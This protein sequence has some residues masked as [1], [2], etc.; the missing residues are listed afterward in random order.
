MLHGTSELNF[1]VLNPTSFAVKIFFVF[2]RTVE[3]AR[4]VHRQKGFT[5]SV[6]HHQKDG[7]IRRLLIAVTGLLTHRGTYVR[8]EDSESAATVLW[9]CKKIATQWD[10][11]GTAVGSRLAMHYSSS[12]QA[13]WEFKRFGRA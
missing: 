2:L 5:L 10:P 12:V 7:D 4:L 11:R 6:V 9:E 3:L 8:T 1:F 13:L